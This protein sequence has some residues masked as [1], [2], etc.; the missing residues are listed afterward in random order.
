MVA[1]LFSLKGVPADEAD[2]IRDLLAQ[3]G[4]AFYETSAGFFGTSIAAIWLDDDAQ[5][6]Q[7]KVLIDQYQRER[8]ENA[9]RDYA[10]RLSQGMVETFAG[11]LKREPI[12]VIAGIAIVLVI[13]YFSTVP[14]LRAGKFF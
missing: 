2:E 3:H 14:F 12:K 7:A 10:E 4:I 5:L 8:A 6:T 9:Q 11:K 1:L 13:I